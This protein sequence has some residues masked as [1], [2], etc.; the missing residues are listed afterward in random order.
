MQNHFTP[1]TS[2]K[3]SVHI[4]KQTHI[5]RQTHTLCLSFDERQNYFGTLEF[6]FFFFSCRA[7]LS[8][9]DEKPKN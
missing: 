3:I 7:W 6:L 9:C 8:K 2:S 5:H 4:H 1:F